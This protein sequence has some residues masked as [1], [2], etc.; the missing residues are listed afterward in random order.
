[1]TALHS[2]RPTLVPLLAV[3]GAVAFAVAT[4]L[5]A[6]VPPT[7][8]AGAPADPAGLDEPLLDA[9]LAATGEDADLCVAA[10]CP[11]VDPAAEL[12]RVR[13]DVTF[14]ADRLQ[15]DPADIVA[16]V[17]LADAS[18]LEGRVTGDVA[19]YTRALAAADAALD[20]QPAYVPAQA[21]KA[22]VLVS[23]HRFPEA[24]D[25]ART[26]LA[27]DPANTTALGVLGDASLEL[28]DLAGAGAAYQSLRL[29]GA[30][31]ASLV[32]D[33]RLAFVRGDTAGAVAADQAAVAA[34]GSEGLEGDQLAFFSVT[35][36]ETLVATGDPHAARAAFEDA[37]AAR[38]D[39]PAALAGL[40]KLD[41]FGGDL[42]AAIT[43][44]STAVAA[45]PTPDWL[46]RRA[47]L[48]ELRGAAGDAA[49]AAADRATVEAIAQLAGEA[50]SV[51]DRGLSLWLSDRGQEPE[52]AVR[53]ARDELAVRPDVYGYD[54]L[55]WALV[56]AG[57]AAAAD[58]PMRAALAAGTRDARLWYHAGVIAAELGRTDEARAY[59]QDALALGPALEPAARARATAT[60]GSLR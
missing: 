35:L 31:A 29:A 53:L 40:A 37:L 25:L 1:M 7:S 46:A 9:P 51:Y 32:R 28:G 27:R 11:A 3:A 60:L 21:S 6:T 18:A 44:L 14:W 55:A 2:R 52:R 48:Y 26:I 57:D 59:L 39:L 16:A 12:A 4:Q 5:A 33:G 19:A 30:S 17:K 36:G 54:T 56:N 49:A 20:R 23:L 47:D 13:D 58:A 43:D 41:A 34:A 38:P 45:V 50:G 10:T 8:P 22:T 15:A 42:D 24:R